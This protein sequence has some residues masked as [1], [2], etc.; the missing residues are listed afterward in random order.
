MCVRARVCRV[1]PSVSQRAVW[2]DPPAQ[3]HRAG[4]DQLP[5]RH[6]QRGPLPQRE[7]VRLPGHPLIPRVLR[8]CM[9]TIG[10]MPTTHAPGPE[11]L[12]IIAETSFTD[13][14]QLDIPNH[15]W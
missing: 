6:T 12:S 7:H 4:A 3:P 11:E 14:H 15:H 8:R 2:I 9:S 10:E 13:G 1:Q 5:D